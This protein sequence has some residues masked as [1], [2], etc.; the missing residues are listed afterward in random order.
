MA[1][2]FVH[3]AQTVTLVAPY[4]V[5]AGGGLL[6]GAIFGIALADAAQGS[7]VETRRVGSFDAPKATG[8]SWT[9]GAPLYWDNTAKVLT[10]T[11]SSN[12]LVG[13]AEQAQASSDT[14]GRAIL[15]GQVSA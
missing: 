11:A 13:A 7:P 14:V 4:A 5:S 2:S 12:R 6:V 1:R 9:Q 10:T 3:P 15:T 8:Q